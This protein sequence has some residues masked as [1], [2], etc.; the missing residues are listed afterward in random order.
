MNQTL[1]HNLLTDG[2]AITPPAKPANADV[3]LFSPV[4]HAHA[5]VSTRQTALEPGVAGVDAPKS[6]SFWINPSNVV[7]G[8]ARVFGVGPTTNSNAQYVLSIIPGSTQ[9]STNQCLNFSIFTTFATAFINFSS[10]Q[11]ILKGRWTHVVITYDGSESNTG[12]ELYINGVRDASINRTSGGTYTGALNDS[13]N[14]F[15]TS[16][17]AASTSRYGGDLARFAIWST[18]LDQTE[19]DE[20]YA[21]GVPIDVDGVSFYSDIV[22]YWP[23]KTDMNCLNNATFNLGSVT[24]ISTRNV[25]LGPDYER[26]S[27]FNG[28]PVNTAYVSF[29]ALYKP[30]AGNTVYWNGRSGT[31]HLANGNLVKFT[32][33]QSTLGTTAPVTMIDDATYDL[34]GGTAGVFD[35]TD[36]INF[37]SRFTSPS[38]WIDASYWEST[39]GL[40]GETY[41]SASTFSVT[42]P[43]YNF[44]GRVVNGTLG[45]EYFV[46]HF[47][48]DG[49]DFQVNLF[50]RSSGGTWSKQVVWSGTTEMLTETAILD[51]GSNRY[52]LLSR[53]NAVGGGL[54][55][56]YSTDGA[57]T[58]SSPVDTGL[59]VGTAMADM[60]L[61]PYGNIVVIWADRD[62]GYIRIS[63]GNVVSDVISDP[64]DWNAG[65]IIFEGY[66]TDVTNILG[67]P[68]IIRDGW[69][70]T[71]SFSTEFSSSRADLY[72]GYGRID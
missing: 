68:Q 38:T 26:L 10:S 35:G 6:W 61:D 19:V 1:F 30:Q 40:T 34:R 50:K 28:Y 71:V 13:N 37:S 3:M 42:E 21:S 27:I 7:T 36:I 5:N 70:Y 25:P 15:F 63:Q 29:G 56:M 16:A 2:G 53:S 46:P 22:A 18:E 11:K 24:N 59:A 55:M 20:L 60:C 69:N 12:F 66:S 58:W 52:I 67:Y 8:S 9:N 44:Y 33:N 49:T 65:S 51:A 14:R 45:G 48:N 57:A 62:D 17:V 64:T 41:G 32:F 72:F 23:M 47:E 54:Y 31:S 4:S 43:I 39:D